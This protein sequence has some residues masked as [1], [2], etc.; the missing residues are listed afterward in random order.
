[1]GLLFVHSYDLYVIW[2][3]PVKMLPEKKQVHQE[4]QKNDGR[5]E[6]KQISIFREPQKKSKRKSKK[7][8]KKLKNSK[9]NS[10]RR[11]RKRPRKSTTKPTEEA[12]S[13]ILNPNTNSKGSWINRTPTSPP[14]NNNLS[15]MRK[16]CGTRFQWA[17][18]STQASK[19]NTPSFDQPLIQIKQLNR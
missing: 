16:T 14:N 15:T 6:C 11:D 5:K 18:P 19:A 2:S 7:T 13:T 9:P 17:S 8:T 4:A 3:M 10:K 1:M 12:K